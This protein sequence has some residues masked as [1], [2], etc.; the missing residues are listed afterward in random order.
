MNTESEILSII[1]RKGWDF[2]IIENILDNVSLKNIPNFLYMIRGIN[3]TGIQVNLAKFWMNN[4][5]NFDDLI[6]IFRIHESPDNI[7]NILRIMAKYRSL[8]NKMKVVASLKNCKDINHYDYM[9]FLMYEIQRDDWSKIQEEFRYDG[10]KKF[11]YN[12]RRHR[13][14]EIHKL[15]DMQIYSNDRQYVNTKEIVSQRF[16]EYY[17]KISLKSMKKIRGKEYSGDILFI[18]FFLVFL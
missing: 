18:F 14:K 15:H 12:I 1:R 16:R 5:L 17:A 3:H 6:F 13:H 2:G 7:Y 8:W 10:I 11:L 9:R 4:S